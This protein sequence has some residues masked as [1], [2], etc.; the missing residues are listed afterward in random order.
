MCRKMYPLPLGQ[1]SYTWGHCS[2]AGAV[3]GSCDIIHRDLGI[4]SSGFTTHSY[5]VLPLHSAKPTESQQSPHLHTSNPLAAALPGG[6]QQGPATQQGEL[7]TV[8]RQRQDQVG[9]RQ[10][11]PHAVLCHTQRGTQSGQLPAVD[12]ERTPHLYKDRNCVV[13][14]DCQALKG[15]DG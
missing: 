9:G 2:T 11:H 14:Q 7:L 8:P 5:R 15:Q 10:A 1:V 6:H 12:R 3:R 13:N 4:S